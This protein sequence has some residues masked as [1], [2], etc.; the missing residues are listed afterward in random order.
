MKLVEEY[1]STKRKHSEYF[2]K[3]SPMERVKHS[4][5]IIKLKTEIDKIESRIINGILSLVFDYNKIYNEL[6]KHELHHFLKGNTAINRFVINQKITVGLEYN[7]NH[8]DEIISEFKD[9]CVKAWEDLIITNKE[10]KELDDFC[11]ENKIDK[12]QQYIIEQEISRKYTDGIDLDKVIKDYYVKENQSEEE[13]QKILKKEYKKHVEVERIKNVLVELDTDIISEI[14]WLDSEK[15]KL[16][17]TIHY[18][19]NFAIYLIVINGQI[20]NGYEFDIGFSPGT[21][22]SLKV[23][24]SNETFINADRTRLIDIISD[25]VCYSVCSKDMNLSN[26]L[27]LKLNVRQHINRIY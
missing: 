1:K 2:K 14:D 12:T 8:R 15:S 3:Y 19:T 11:R 22:K 20:S 24:I 26:F 18:E 7:E 10:R 6:I 21:E 13:I 25:A 16:I 27:A 9:L 4:K 17:K 23:M 5:E